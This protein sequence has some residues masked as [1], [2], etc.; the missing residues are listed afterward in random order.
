MGI[1]IIIPDVSFSESNIGQVTPVGNNPLVSLSIFGDDSVVGGE[2]AASYTVGYNPANTTQRA[3]AWSIV[4]G[5][6]YAAIG[7]LNGVLSVL[8]GASQNNV[9]I[10]VSSVDN[11]SITAEK[12]IV[13]T[14]SAAPGPDP[15][16]TPLEDLTARLYLKNGTYFVTDVTLAS[17]DY[18]K[19]KFASDGGHCVVGS[20]KVFNMDDDSNLIEVDNYGI[21][22]LGIKSKIA[23]HYIYSAS[24]VV[25]LTPYTIVAKE[26]SLEIDPSLGTPLVGDTYTYNEALPIAIGALLLQNNTVTSP[27]NGDIYGVE[28]YGSGGQLKHRFIPQPDLTFLDEITGVSY[29]HSGS[30]TIIY[31]DN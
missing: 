5:S 24:G 14:Y 3:I 26:T 20:R 30:G 15:G 2:E 16:Y 21:G 13:V 29:T 31:A 8:Q 11:P 12:Q 6:E 27:F 4:S 23:G 28:I 19:A 10:R 22:Y 7:Q 1:A 25:N 9:T 18:I 17:G